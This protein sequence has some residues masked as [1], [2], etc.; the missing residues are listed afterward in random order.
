MKAI[1]DLRL[2]ICQLS[3][4]LPLFIL[5]VILSLIR[6]FSN[7]P[8]SNMT[9][10]VSLP[11]EVLL[12]ICQYLD[13]SSLLRAEQVNKTWLFSIRNSLPIWRH[14]FC[15]LKCREGLRVWREIGKLIPRD[16]LDVQLYRQ[17]VVVFSLLT[18]ALSEKLAMNRRSKKGI[19]SG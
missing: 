15:L 14:Q 16:C 11:T 18:E 19:G 13:L 9:T 6:T 3:R 1:C 4:T 12:K 2:K 5:V 17:S 8:F 7:S 10:I